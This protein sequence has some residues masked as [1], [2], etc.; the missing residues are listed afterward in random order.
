[1]TMPEFD[2]VPEKLDRL[3]DQLSGPN[4]VGET[5]AF[6]RTFLV[7]VAV[8]ASLPFLLGSYGA[9]QFALFMAYGLLALSLTIVWGYAGILSFGQ[10][11]FLGIA[12]YTYA[13]VSLNVGGALGATVAIPAAVLAATVSAFVLGYFMFYGDVR[14]V[15]VAIMTL[16]VTLVIGTFLG[17]TAGDG[18]TIGSVPLGGANGIP[19]LPDLTIGIGDVAVV[20]SGTMYYW[21]TLVVVLGTYLGLR[22]LV[23]GR[24]GYALVAIREDED[25]AEMLGYDVRRLK[26]LVF[27]FSGTL[28]GVAGVFYVTYFNIVNPEPFTLLWA[29][30]PVLWVTFGGRETL[31]GALVG[32]ISIEWIRLTLSR[33]VP[34]FAI[35]FVGAILLVSVLLVPRGVVPGI[36]DSYAF[37]ERRGLRDGV[38]VGGRRI[39]AG[40][41]RR[42]RA[43]GARVRGTLPDAIES[44]SPE[45]SRE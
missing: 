45:V 26:L 36:R 37:F 13:L 19:G 6:W 3:R 5:P 34:E 22:V 33:T 35:V 21:I 40:L 4:T 29:T 1:M 42:L 9:N 11:A 14:D 27:T 7:A 25:R 10:I 20:F 24:L 30:Y 12:G 17:R 18:W 39:A 41:R 16:V 38:V 31:T 23:N 28:A 44:Q 2:F 8:F 15:Y 32:A 43:V